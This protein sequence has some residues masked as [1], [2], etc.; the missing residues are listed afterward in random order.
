MTLR[1]VSNRI[2]FWTVNNLYQADC[3]SG[4]PACEMNYRASQY[5]TQTHKVKDSGDAN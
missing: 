2:P 1:D 3:H 5:L 4:H